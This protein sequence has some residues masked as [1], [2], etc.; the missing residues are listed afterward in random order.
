MVSL[1]AMCAKI[2]LICIEKI[3]S[4]D[5]SFLGKSFSSKILELK[6]LE[7]KGLTNYRDPSRFFASFP[8]KKCCSTDMSFRFWEKNQLQGTETF[9]TEKGLTCPTIEIFRFL[10]ENESFPLEW[11]LRFGI[12]N[13]DL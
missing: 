8:E 12:C 9:G 1:L 4:R 10:R 5:F 6:L 3:R 11:F 7:L 13:M 2:A